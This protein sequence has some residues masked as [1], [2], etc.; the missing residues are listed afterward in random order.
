MIKIILSIIAL[1]TVIS[2]VV[3][4]QNPYEIKCGTVTYIQKGEFGINSFKHTWDNFGMLQLF[5]QEGTILLVNGDIKKSRTA[6]IINKKK[7]KTWQ[8]DHVAKT[9]LETPKADL[10]E[11]PVIPNGPKGQALISRPFFSKMCPGVEINGTNVWTWKGVVMEIVTYE[12]GKKITTSPTSINGARVS[13]KTFIPPSR[14]YT[15]LNEVEGLG[16]I[17][18]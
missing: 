7:G 18:H 15:N 10:S 17:I 9:L 2:S 5:E 3:S 12:A 11:F 4:A 16:N 13:K 6:V 14:G 8:I 1:I